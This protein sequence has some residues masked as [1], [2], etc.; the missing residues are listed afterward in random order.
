[1]H[2][3]KRMGEEEIERIN[4]DRRTDETGSLASGD[5]EEEEE[6]VVPFLL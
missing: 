4:K 5:D 2:G 1:M 3:F 6:V